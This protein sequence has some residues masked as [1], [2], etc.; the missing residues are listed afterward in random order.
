MP[1]ISEFWIYG[2][3]S[4]SGRLM[5][6]R[7]FPGGG[8]RESPMQPQDEPIWIVGSEGPRMRRLRA[9][10]AQVGYPVELIP[11][12]AETLE[13]VALR[14]PSA[15][16]LDYARVDTPG[17]ELC[18]QLRK[19]SGIAIIVLG[20]GTPTSAAITALDHGAD[21]YITDACGWAELLARLRAALRRAR[22]TVPPRSAP[23]VS[24]VLRLD[25][26]RRRI[27][28]SDNELYLP[29]PGIRPAALLHEPCQR[30][31][32]GSRRFNTRSGARAPDRPRAACACPSRVSAAS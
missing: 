17:L 28:V 21:D 10:L 16:F 2:A 5:S 23:L 14:P 29:P 22:G 8:V 7:Y 12:E 25:P 11:S 19:Q 20:A 15:V 1:V 3:P 30:S 18:H 31:D 27:R 9:L 6:A 24:G 13:R 26:D 32:T 4:P